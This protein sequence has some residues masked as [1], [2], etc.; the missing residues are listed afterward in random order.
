MTNNKK[1]QPE[2]SHGHIFSSKW[3]QKFNCLN[4]QWNC[5]STASLPSSDNNYPY[6]PIDETPYYLHDLNDQLNI[7]MNTLDSACSMFSLGKIKKSKYKTRKE[8]EFPS[9]VCVK[10]ESSGRHS[11]DEECR[12]YHSLK[13]LDETKKI[14]TNP[15]HISTVCSTESNYVA[16]DTDNFH[17]QNQDRDDTIE[18]TLL[19]RS[20]SSISNPSC[21]DIDDKLSYDS[22][23][24]DELQILLDNNEGISN[25]GSQSKENKVCLDLSFSQ[26]TDHNEMKNVTA[27]RSKDSLLSYDRFSECGEE[28]SLNDVISLMAES[29]VDEVLMTN[30]YSDDASSISG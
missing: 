10:N 26:S 19:A 8:K 15:T 13:F 16:D 21:F 24:K 14:H 27:T 4:Y 18:I 6:I 20:I 23:D 9:V 1:N 29:E 17:R 25:L 30:I 3:V 7:M 11:Y 28:N 12:D 5:Y 2:L 22:D